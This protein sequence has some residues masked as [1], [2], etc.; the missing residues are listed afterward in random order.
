MDVFIYW[1]FVQDERTE[2]L[3]FFNSV[4]RKQK[5]FRFRKK[6]E[7]V[8][9]DRILFFRWTMPLRVFHSKV[10]MAKNGHSWIKNT[11]TFNTQL[12][13]LREAVFIPALVTHQL[14]SSCQVINLCHV[15]HYLPQR[16]NNH[17]ESTIMCELCKEHGSFSQ[18]VMWS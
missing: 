7:W 10:Q 9:D 1:T 14:L 15:L 2:I 8:N 17:N 18:A 4:T 5:S 12:S 13:W 3:S 11:C 16:W 6:W